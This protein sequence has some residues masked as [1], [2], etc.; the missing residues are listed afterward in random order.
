M[1]LTLYSKWHRGF[2]IELRGEHAGR[3]VNPDVSVMPYPIW[4][5]ACGVSL[6]NYKSIK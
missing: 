6:Y 1:S 3:A 4:I 5:F 2:P